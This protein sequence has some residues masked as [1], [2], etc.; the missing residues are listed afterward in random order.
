[1]G[2]RFS[3]LLRSEHVKEKRESGERSHSLFRRKENE[4]PKKANRD[5]RAEHERERTN[6]RDRH[7]PVWG[8][9]EKTYPQGKNTGTETKHQD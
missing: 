5:E 9:K 3:A 7:P 1:M 8:Q 4:N 2:K 6:V